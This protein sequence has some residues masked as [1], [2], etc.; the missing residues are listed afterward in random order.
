[1][2]SKQRDNISNAN[3]DEQELIILVDVLIILGHLSYTYIEEI[4]LFL[5]GIDITYSDA[6]TTTNNLLDLIKGRRV[7]INPS[8]FREIILNY[9]QNATIRLPFLCQALRN[10]LYNLF[11]KQEEMVDANPALS[12]VLGAIREYK[13][14]FG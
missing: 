14:N 5:F 8:V 1:V 9:P 13:K 3:Q 4:V 7:E 12:E 11:K 6:H 10:N 2:Y